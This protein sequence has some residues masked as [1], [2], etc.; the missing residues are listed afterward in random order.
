MRSNIKDV[1]YQNVT[2]MSNLSTG[3]QKTAAFRVK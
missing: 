3:Q 1:T 2:D